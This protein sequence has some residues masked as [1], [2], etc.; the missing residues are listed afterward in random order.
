ME[1]AAPFCGAKDT[2]KTCTEALNGSPAVGSVPVRGTSRH[3]LMP[4]SSYTTGASNVRLS[5]VP[6]MGAVQTSIQS[7]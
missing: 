4:I 1:V 5:A 6:Q 7:G 3:R 2:V